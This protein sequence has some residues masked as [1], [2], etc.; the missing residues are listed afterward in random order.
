MRTLDEIK[1]L[2]TSTTSEGNNFYVF[3]EVALIL[4][5]NG[6]ANLVPEVRKA[7]NPSGQYFQNTGVKRAIELLE[8]T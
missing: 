8:N 1:T 2:P 3:E 5:T 6:F 4:G 7:A